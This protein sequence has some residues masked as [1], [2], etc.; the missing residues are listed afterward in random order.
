MSLIPLAAPLIRLATTDAEYAQDLR[1]AVFDDQAFSGLVGA[2]VQDDD[3]AELTSTQWHWYASWRQELGGGL[4]KVVLDHLTVSA[5][6]RFA[7]FEVRELVLRDP[8]TNADALRADDAS[9]SDRPDAIDA[10]GLNWLSEQARG[11]RVEEELKRR[12]DEGEELTPGE[13]F[14]LV[15]DDALNEVFELM[16]DARQ[17]A[18][19]AS[20]FLL[21][22]LTSLNDP[23]G[24]L[25]TEEL[26]NFARDRQIDPTMTRRWGLEP[27]TP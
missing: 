22:R 16:R 3:L 11:K 5:S 18:T 4:N 26:R 7:R 27:L 9:A 14:E 2:E 13:A 8:E 1:D 12:R 24:S 6:T 19:E 23:R 21:K 15:R 20:W 10:I 17:C 25:V